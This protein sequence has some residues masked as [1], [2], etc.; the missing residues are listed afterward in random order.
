[1]MRRGQATPMSGDKVKEEPTGAMGSPG[2]EG[3]TTKAEYNR[4]LVSQEKWQA[5][6]EIRTQ[7]KEG[8]EIIKERQ[9][10]HTTQGLSRQQAAAVQMKK[11][12]ES[13]EA[14]REQNLTLGRAVY[15]EVAGWR[16]GAKQT[17]DEY[18]AYGKKVKEQIKASNAT[19][20]ALAAL[21]ESKKAQAAIT[22]DD[23]QKK[24][25][26]RKDLRDSIAEQA[27]K[28]AEKVRQETGD[29]VTDASKRHFYEQRL[30]SANDTKADA[31]RWEK[32]RK[33]EAEAF[34]EAQKKRR[35]KSKSARQAASKSRQ[36]LITAR[37][38]EAV[39]MREEKKKLA[40]FHRQRLQEEYQLRAATVK[41]AQPIRFRPG[42]GETGR[43]GSG[44][45]GGEGRGNGSPICTLHAC[46]PH[47]LYL[48]NASVTRSRLMKPQAS[49]AT[50][51]C[52]QTLQQSRGVLGP[53]RWPTPS[54]PSPT[55]GQPRPKR[56]EQ[57]IDE[58]G[59]RR[60]YWPPE[61]AVSFCSVAL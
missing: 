60:T 9:R 27:K 40:E 12:S 61:C 6:E 42:E 49:S 7:G 29:A 10:R 17:K 25:K 54:T 1:M 47:F 53:T 13:L 34:A 51:T 16:Q 5:A 23:D 46:P 15:E 30:K 33:E 37:T 3:I 8:E 55:S 2:K 38:E 26:A 18:A 57:P 19:A 52:S 58:A 39:A 56:S 43:E 50:P 48:M 44:E 28:Q 32:E 24:E 41:G 22:R 21:S 20:A 36:A 4:W 35:N 31:V 45:G 11:A 59:L 14:H